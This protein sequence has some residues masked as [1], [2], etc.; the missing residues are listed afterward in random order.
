MT[1]SNFERILIVHPFGIGDALFVTPVLRALHDQGAKKIDLVLGSRTRELFETNPFVD[2]I[3]VIDRD[4][5]KKQSIFQNWYETAQ[6]LKTLRK[7]HYELFLDFSL[8]RQYAFFTLLF[9]NISTRVGFSYKNRGIF[10]NR[11]MLLKQGFSERAVAEYYLAL[12]DL[13]SVPYSTNHLE[14]YLTSE[15]EKRSVEILRS[16][17]CDPNASYL[18]VAPG[19]GESWGK[20]AR[21][22]RWPVDHFFRLIQK[23]EKDVVSFEKV[24]VLGGKREWE[25]GEALTQL[26]PS[27][28]RNLCGQLPLR[29]T[30]AA[31]KHAQLLLANDGGLVHMASAVGTPTIAIFGPVD[32]KVYGPYP[33]SPERVAV[34]NDGPECRPCY[35]NMR[36]NSTCEHINCLNMLEPEYVF[37]KAERAGLFERLKSAIRK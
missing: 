2:Q 19:G 6:F 29:S 9:L 1:K 17:G 25:L 30:A 14:L 37:Q 3:F 26:E 16:N 31:L 7:N 21:L 34:T 15:D 23:I 32:P 4:R 24:L 12:L 27:R 10:L 35:Q 20:D 22:K 8:G 33:P 36:Y 11:R 28:F 18:A 5:L 13:I